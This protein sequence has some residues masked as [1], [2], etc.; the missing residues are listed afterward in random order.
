MLGRE[1]VSYTQVITVMD[2]QEPEIVSGPDTITV[3]VDPWTCVYNGILPFAEVAESCSSSEIEAYV[4]GGGYIETSGSYAGGDLQ[5]FGVRMPIG[6]HRVTNIFRDQCD[7]ITVFNYIVLVTDGVPPVAIAKESLIVSLTDDQVQN[8]EQGVAKIFASSFDSG[9]HDGACGSVTSCVLLDSELSDPILQDGVQVVDEE[10][11]LIYRA[12]QCESDGIF[13]LITSD[14]KGSRVVEEIP[15]VICKEAVAFC[16]TDI[17]EQR[18]ALVVT[19]EEGLTAV[20]W[21]TVTVDDKSAATFACANVIVNCGDDISVAAIGQPA[22][23]SSICT[24]G[25]LSHIDVTDVQSCGN[26]T[27]IRQWFLDDEMICAQEITIRGGGATFD[28]LTIKWPIHHDGSTEVGV[29]RECVVVGQDADGN[30]VMGIVDSLTNIEMNNSLICGGEVSAT[31][32]WCF[33]DCDLI[34]ASFEDES[35]A[36]D[37]ACRKILRRWTVID[38]CTYEPNTQLDDDIGSGDEFQAVNDEWLGEGHWLPNI[39][40]GEPC[41]E[42][43]KFSGESGFRYFRYTN[44]DVDGYYTYNQV[45]SIIDETPPVITAPDTLVVSISDGA[46]SKEDDFNACFATTA[47][48][49]SLIDMCGDVM[50]DSEDA[51]WDIVI[52]DV[53]GRV[54][55]SRSVSGDTVS[56]I[57]PARGPGEDIIINWSAEDGCVNSAVATTYVRFVDEKLPTPICIQDISTALLPSTGEVAIWAADYDIGSFDNCGPVDL[58]FKN[59]DGDLVPSLTFT[60]AD[61]PSG[62]NALIELEMYAVDQFGLED[63]CNVRINIDDTQDVCPNVNN[64]AALIAGEIRTSEDVMVE[65]AMVQLSTGDAMM[66]PS[67]GEYLFNNNALSAY[68]QIDPFKDDDVTNGISVIDMILIQRHILGLAQIEGPYQIIAADVNADMR[69]SSVDLVQLRRIILGLDESFI[70]NT[71]WRFMPADYQF[72]NPQAPWPFDEII[73]IQSLGA[74]RYFDDFIGVKIGDVNGNVQ[75]NSSLADNRSDRAISIMIDDRYVTE[76]QS[77]EV[78]L[79]FEEPIDLIGLQVALQTG[80]LQMDGWLEGHLQVEQDQIVKLDRDRLAAAWQY[81]AASDATKLTEEQSIFTLIFTATESGYLSD[82]ISLDPSQMRSLAYDLEDREYKVE[83]DFASLVLDFLTLDQNEPNP[84]RG[85]TK[86]GFFIPEE[87]V[88]TLEFFDVTGRLIHSH[89]GRYNAGAHDIRISKNELKSEGIIRYRLTY[90]G[91]SLSKTMVM[92]R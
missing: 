63:F 57:T 7:N 42:C 17:G 66:T 68:Y 2:T 53:D 62:L 88:I 24:N 3:S 54:L 35:L 71:S 61:L 83:L 60:C 82:M 13:E 25:E 67:S 30:D 72:S 52:T 19:D 38:W 10:G 31:P 48:G 81:D 40:E 22:I 59:D 27:I 49:A 84:F 85:E 75:A 8:N 11:R 65:N 91:T 41:E 76:G 51:H 92:I 20:S 26:G 50:L 33:A 14:E 64:A 18:V 86:I 47:A 21:T 44:V 46:I 37:D 69:I 39:E 23:G 80:G 9:S 55:G 56:F 4:S 87:D 58:F 74:N 6:S 15:Y 70:S 34:Q 12:H 36:V 16:C 43:E 5:L 29:Q 45:I 1:F 79:H 78:P 89:E 32:T 73:E 28:P 77:I 90:Q